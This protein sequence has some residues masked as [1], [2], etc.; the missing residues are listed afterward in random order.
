MGDI[1]RYGGNGVALAATN[2]S[3]TNVGVV[4]ANLISLLVASG[5]G[6]TD[7]AVTP[8]SYQTLVVTIV[9]TSFHFT[10][11][12]LLP[13]IVNENQV[14]SIVDRVLNRVFRGS[15]DFTLISATKGTTAQPTQNGS[16]YIVV[17]GDTL[18]SIARRYNTTWQELAR[19]NNLTGNAINLLRIG[20]SLRITRTAQTQ[21]TAPVIDLPTVQ[22]VVR[23]N[24]ET[25]GQNAPKTRSSLDDFL[26][27]FTQKL[28]IS[29]TTLSVLAFVVFIVVTKK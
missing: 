13:N 27:D 25:S 18:S 15:Y 6:V 24:Q 14:R 17:R 11:T 9:D 26:D 8:Q 3:A 10:V 21:P 2:D 4:K 5:L 20:Q 1:Y 28:G 22:A 12:P 29:V 7:V 23:N 19:I 16:T